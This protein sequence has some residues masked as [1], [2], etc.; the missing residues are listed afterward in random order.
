L[1]HFP[2]P[3]FSNFIHLFLPHFLR[4]IH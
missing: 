2:W 4:S 1:S 3:I